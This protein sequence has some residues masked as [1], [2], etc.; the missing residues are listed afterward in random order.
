MAV[1]TLYSHSGVTTE[2]LRVSALAKL[3][4]VRKMR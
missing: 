3:T 2:W 1:S 4:I